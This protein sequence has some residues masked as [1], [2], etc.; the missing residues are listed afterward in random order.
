MTGR[1]YL[2]KDLQSIWQL[3]VKN[4]FCSPW[5]SASSLAGACGL[6]K[7]VQHFLEHFLSSQ[8]TLLSERVF[9]LS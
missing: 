1:T 9:K 3:A 8:K 5:R 2:A 7:Q 6:E 4:F